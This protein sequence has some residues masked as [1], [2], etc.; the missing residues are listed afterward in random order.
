MANKFTWLIGAGHSGVAAGH[1]FTAGKRS[2]GKRTET[3][4]G[5]FEGQYNRQ[6]AGRLCD[7]VD[8][9]I[10][11]TPGPINIPLRSRIG[12]V[13]KFTRL[14]D[15]ALLSLHVNAAR[16]GWGPAHGFTIFHSCRAG[17]ES[18]RLAK[19]V[20][21]ELYDLRL[22]TGL[23]SRGVKAA[24]HAMTTLTRCPALTVEL[25]FMTSKSDVRCL[26][27]TRTQRVI[28]HAL[29]RAMAAF[30]AGRVE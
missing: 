25:G 14:E 30:E 8:N 27:S 5:I 17:K 23:S 2:P 10:L 6:I 15:C 4:P 18:K 7:S 3:D 22:D 26:V 20:E 21:A 29:K 13:N 28:V 1:Y 19:L 9:A 12:F 16:G 11:I 24:L